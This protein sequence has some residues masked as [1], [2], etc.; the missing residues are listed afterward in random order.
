MPLFEYTCRGCGHRFEAFVTASRSAA[1]P[2]C[3]SRELEKQFSTFAARSTGAGGSAA[4][5][6]RFT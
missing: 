3:G 2:D 5:A 6:P 1:C 4:A